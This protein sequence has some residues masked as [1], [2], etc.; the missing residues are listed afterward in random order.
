MKCFWD[1][2]FYDIIAARAYTSVLAGNKK[3]MFDERVKD[4]YIIFDNLG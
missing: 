1:L 3:N 2:N 4:F